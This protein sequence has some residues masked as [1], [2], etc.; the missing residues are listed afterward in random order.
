MCTYSIGFFSARLGVFFPYQKHLQSLS[1]MHAQ[2]LYLTPSLSR[3]TESGW[4]MMARE[5]QLTLSF[6]ISLQKLRKPWK[7]PQT[8]YHYHYHIPQTLFTTTSCTGLKLTSLISCLQRQRVTA[9]KFKSFSSLCGKQL[10]YEG[11][12]TCS[13]ILFIHVKH[14]GLD[15]FI[16]LVCAFVSA[17]TCMCCPDIQ[18]DTDA[19]VP[20]FVPHR[21]SNSVRSASPA[22]FHARSPEAA[23]ETRLCYFHLSGILP[24]HWPAPIP[25]A[26]HLCEATTPRHACKHTHTHT[27]VC[28]SH[29]REKQAISQHLPGWQKSKQIHF[30]LISPCKSCVQFRFVQPHTPMHVCIKNELVTLGKIHHTHS[31]TSTPKVEQLYG[32][33]WLPNHCQGL[34]IGIYLFFSLPCLVEVKILEDQNSIYVISSIN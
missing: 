21:G 23:E 8:N 9:V 29:N 19:P 13:S 17:D 24:A 31:S 6:R 32:C 22:A 5:E 1:A 4:C 27:H 7:H 10:Q 28:N 2:S 12:L 34:V 3:R 33:G 11:Q 14:M 18:S 16:L 26:R 30:S 20:N 25:A 15:L